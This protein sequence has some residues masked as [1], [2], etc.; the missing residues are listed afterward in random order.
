MFP[1]SQASVSEPLNLYSQQ[2]SSHRKETFYKQT[3]S[4]CIPAKLYLQKLP[5]AEYGPQPVFLL[6]PVLVFQRSCLNF[7]K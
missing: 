5:V 3:G 2:D 6:N 1:V 7:L 4:A